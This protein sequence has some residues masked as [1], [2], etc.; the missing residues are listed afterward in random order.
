MIEKLFPIDLPPGL[1]HN[2][3]RLQARGR[4]YDGNGVR[5]WQGTTQPVGGWTARTTTGAT[6]AGIPNA[7]IA[8]Q[9][10]DGNS[11]LVIG[12]T[13]NLYVVSSANVVSDITPA[14]GGSSL[15]DLA[16]NPCQWQLDTFG[17]YLLAVYSGAGTNPGKNVNLYYWAGDPS[18]L[19]VPVDT[20]LLAPSRG[21]GVVTTPE[22]FLFMLQGDDPA[23]LSDAI[24]LTFR[25][26]RSGAVTT[27]LVD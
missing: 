26:A 17:S 8:Y 3:T 4:W 18:A 19:P 1:Y 25:A 20:V 12:T 5:F 9:T 14:A 7:A 22:R 13:T 11:W 24:Q 16:G 21:L 10:N 27:A 6:I 2:G 23:T 15:F